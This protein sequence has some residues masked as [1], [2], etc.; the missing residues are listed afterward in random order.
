MER[1][2]EI[3]EHLRNCE[4]EDYATP[5]CCLRFL[6][7]LLGVRLLVGHN[8]DVEGRSTLRNVGFNFV[9]LVIDYDLRV[10]F[11]SRITLPRRPCF[12]KG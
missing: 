7:V 3:D 4:L 2:K 12:S 11:P 5:G 6:N 8:L 10:S 1:E 9:D